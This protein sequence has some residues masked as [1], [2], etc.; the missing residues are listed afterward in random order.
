MGN[1]V[2]R[3]FIAGGHKLLAY[4]DIIILILLTTSLFKVNIFNCLK[5][6]ILVV[7]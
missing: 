5:I 2:Y 4:L 6:S 1:M 7:L 3:S